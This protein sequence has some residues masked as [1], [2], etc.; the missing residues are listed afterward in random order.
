MFLGDVVKVCE[1]L[2]WVLQIGLCDMIVEMV[3]VDLW[4]V[5]CYVLLK[6]YGLDLLVVVGGV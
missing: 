3:V 6:D 1:K 2:G 4:I 5:C